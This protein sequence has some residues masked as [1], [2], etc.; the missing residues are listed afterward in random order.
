MQLLSLRALWRG[1]R[2]KSL[3]FSLIFSMAVMGFSLAG[4]LRSPM[5][6]IGL[7]WPLIFLLPIFFIGKTAKFE[8][9]LELR[10]E[11]R[12]ICCFILI[13]GSILLSLG[14]WMYGRHLREAYADSFQPGPLY[15]EVIEVDLPRGPRGKR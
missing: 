3:V 4:L 12:R 13:Y 5:R 2:G 1:L 8:R 14:F 15:K 6:A 11:F 9:G 7:W 10:P